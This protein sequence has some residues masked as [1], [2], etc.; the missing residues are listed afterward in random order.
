MRIFRLRN[1]N[2]SLTTVPRHGSIWN[3]AKERVRN[4]FPKVAPRSARSAWWLG[5]PRGARRHS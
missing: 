1:H 2:R 5:R 4:K 3:D